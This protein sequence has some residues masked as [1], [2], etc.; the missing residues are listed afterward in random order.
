MGR[1]TPEYGDP[2]H[3]GRRMRLWTAVL[4]A[5]RGHTV[6]VDHVCTAT[7]SVAGVDSAALAVILNATP[8]ELLHA[9]ARTASELEDLTLTLGEG[10]GADAMSGGPVLVADLTA[11]ECRHRWPVFAPAALLTGVRAVF[12]LPL[13]IGGIRLGVLDLYRAHAGGLGAEQL[14]DALVLADLA[15]AVLLGHRVDRDDPRPERIGLQHPEVHQA[16]GMVTVQLGVT[17]E[18]ALT[19]LRAYAYSHDRRLQD[20]AADIVARRL[21]LEPARTHGDRGG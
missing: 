7:V 20:V 10:P 2:M 13:R 21:R 12:A 16:T 18:V 19:R 9:T 4:E 8:R 6:E 15:C 5:A 11:T 3:S 1:D 14:A 17:A